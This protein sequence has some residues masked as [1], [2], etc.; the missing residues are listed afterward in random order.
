[1]DLDDM[2]NDTHY[3]QFNSFC[4]KFPTPSTILTTDNFETSVPNYVNRQSL[5][6]AQNS[7]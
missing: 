6:E 1:M 7:L 2:F 4:E 3:G 5:L